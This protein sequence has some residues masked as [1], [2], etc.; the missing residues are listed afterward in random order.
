MS[1]LVG[2]SE[3]FSCECFGCINYN[4]VAGSSSVNAVDEKLSRNCR[5]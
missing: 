4:A 3:S 5:T 2:Y 1:D